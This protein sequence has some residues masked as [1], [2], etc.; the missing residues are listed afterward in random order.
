MQDTQAGSSGYTCPKLQ[1]RRRQPGD[2]QVGTWGCKLVKATL[3]LYHKACNRQAGAG[4]TCPDPPALP[5]DS[6]LLWAQQRGPGRRSRPR[7]AP[8][9]P[10]HA[11]RGRPQRGAQ[12]PIPTGSDQPRVP[13]ATPPPPW[14]LGPARHAARTPPGLNFPSSQPR[15]HSS[16][17]LP[18]GSHRQ[19]WHDLHRAAVAEVPSGLRRRLGHDHRR[20]RAARPPRG[21][22]RRPF[23]AL[24][25]ADAPAHAHAWHAR[26]AR[27]AWGSR[28]NAG[29][30]PRGAVSWRTV[31][32]LGQS[33]Y[34]RKRETRVESVGRSLGARQRSLVSLR[35]RTEV[36]VKSAEHL[37]GV[38]YP[39]WAEP[40][41]LGNWGV[42]L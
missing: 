23:A 5:S 11:L 7:C 39:V 4:T 22:C 31:A 13:R 15:A 26:H 9:R 33:K 14:V 17:A 36:R 2:S 30:A 21:A 37:G 34:C 38:V 25:P 19:A 16:T 18:P 6:Q 35:T 28:R 12:L 3:K 8:P 29:N 20:L 40:R 1:G 10:G 32:A 42:R 41:G 24:S 27:Q